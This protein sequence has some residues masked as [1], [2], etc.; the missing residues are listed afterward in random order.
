MEKPFYIISTKGE[1]DREFQTSDE[2]LDAMKSS[3]SDSILY[4]VD[5]DGVITMY[6]RKH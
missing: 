6:K 3:P 4:R 1:R 5:M 2:A